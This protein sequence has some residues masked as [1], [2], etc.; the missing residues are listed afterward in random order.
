MKNLKMDLNIKE[1]TKMEKRMDMESINGEMDASMKE[2]LNKIIFME[3]EYTIGIHKN[4]MDHGFILLCMDMVHLN[5]GMENPN[6]LDN[7][8]MA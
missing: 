5:L 8:T 1:L 3:R 4:M 7:F 6:I 2:T